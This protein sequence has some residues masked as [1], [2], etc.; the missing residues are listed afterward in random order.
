[1]RRPLARFATF[2][3]A[4]FQVA[5]AAALPIADASLAPAGQNQSA[6]IE[7]ERGRDCAP[8]HTDACLLCQQIA[9]RGALSARPTI[10][11]VARILPGEREWTA[12]ALA[13]RFADERPPS[14]APPSLA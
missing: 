6:H 14:R 4:I 5:I 12:A 3:F 7:S 2:G 8:L 9:V 13:T 10:L 1:M 11:I